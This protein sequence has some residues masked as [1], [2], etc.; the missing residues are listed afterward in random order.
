MAIY[1]SG[2]SFQDAYLKAQNIS[3]DFTPT[4]LVQ[5]KQDINIGY[6]RFN[7][8]IA[9]YFTRKQQFADI[10]AGQQLYQTPIDAI[11]VN[12]VTTKL[13]NGYQYPLEQ[14]RS[15]VDWRWYNIYQYSSSYIQY[16]FVI[17]S[18]QIGLYPIPSYSLAGGLR[19][20]YQP[21]DV[22]LTQDDYTAGTVSV[23]NDGI[24]VTGV[25][26][27]WVATMVGRSF[28]LTDGSDGN[29]YTITAVSSPTSL[30]IETPSVALSA[31]GAT[32]RIGQTFIFPSEYDDVPVDY[33]LA[34][35][36]EARNNSTRA[37]YHNNKFMDQ[38]NDAVE[39]YSSSST[40]NVI[41]EDTQTQNAWLL[42]P[43]PG[44]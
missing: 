39:K 29:W 5:L 1:N 35:F 14:I 15:E 24:T 12:T 27:A 21:Q 10:V 37:T 43:M 28:Q 26:T 13:S 44:S 8:A 31:S 34:R 16:Y 20:I 3:G 6:K 11:R 23:S 18:N 30:T 32:Y 36:F 7:A 19:L 4:T 38:V 25:G 41:T 17:G 2:I 42:P 33:S 9:R 22:D 40:S